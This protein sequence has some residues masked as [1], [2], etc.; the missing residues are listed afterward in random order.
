LS[1]GIARE[2]AGLRKPQR[3]ESLHVVLRSATVQRVRVERFI[4]RG[5]LDRFGSLIVDHYPTLVSL[6]SG[7][8]R[9]VER[10]ADIKDRIEELPRPADA[11]DP[12]DQT[13][14]PAR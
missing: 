8:A 1:A 3:P 14:G 6:Q 2:E 10:A 9:L 11:V 5:F 4:E 12:D 13:P 7:A